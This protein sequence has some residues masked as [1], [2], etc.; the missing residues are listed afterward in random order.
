MLFSW[1]TYLISPSATLISSYLFIFHN[2]SI[3][4]GNK[5]I[6]FTVFDVLPLPLKLAI[7]DEIDST[8]V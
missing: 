8:F 4:N 7:I 3:S 1:Y 2:N 6:D 5:F